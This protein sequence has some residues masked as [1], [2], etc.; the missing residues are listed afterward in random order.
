M[1]F[2]DEA[3]RLAV[4]QAFMRVTS[5]PSWPVMRTLAEEV[6]YKLE[7]KCIHE[8]DEAK[9]ASYRHTAKG[10]HEFWE[11][12]LRLIEIVK[13]EQSPSETFIEVSID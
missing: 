2:R 7:Q 8:D 12:W 5:D 6:I 10:A 3:H 13:L 4:K 11:N 9:A 1:E